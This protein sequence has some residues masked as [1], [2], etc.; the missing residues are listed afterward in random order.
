MTISEKKRV[1]FKTTNLN[2]EEIR[3]LLI[4]LISPSLNN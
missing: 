1:N 3:D 4:H 2:T